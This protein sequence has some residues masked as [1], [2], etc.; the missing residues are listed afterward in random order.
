MEPRITLVTLGVANL[1][2]TRTFYEEVLGWTPAPQ[3]VGDV[4]FFQAGGIALALYP[5]KLLAADARLPDVGGTGFA[6]FTLAHNVRTREEVD[7]VLDDVAR[8][9]G[10]ILKAAE[11][12]SWGG[13]SGYFAD[14]DGVAWEVAWNPG[15]P[16]DA[17][18]IPRFAA[19]RKA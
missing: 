10:R 13:R 11:D 2:R 5:R 3:S 1:D 12:A 14:P 17:E 18:G 19:E 6:G 7:R 16:L 9:G 8:R 15:L 4:V